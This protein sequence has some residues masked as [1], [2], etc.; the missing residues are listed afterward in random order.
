MVAL[1]MTTSNSAGLNSR[2]VMSMSISA[3][4]GRTVHGLLAFV[5]VVHGLDA[6]LGEVDIRDVLHAVLV[7]VLAQ[8]RVTRSDVQ[9]LVI[10]LHQLRDYLLEAVVALVPVEWLGVSGFKPDYFV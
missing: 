3:L 8:A 9:Y 1:S 2:S 6:D 10:R 7:H 5:L 4:A